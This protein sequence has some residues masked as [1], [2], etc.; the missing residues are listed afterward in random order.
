MDKQFLSLMGLKPNPSLGPG[1][2]RR[3]GSGSGMTIKPDSNRQLLTRQL[4]KVFLLFESAI[5]L[6][7]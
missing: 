6:E 2:I 5:Y 1:K 7:M 4:F 3:V